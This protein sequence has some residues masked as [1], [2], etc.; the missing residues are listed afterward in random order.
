MSVGFSLPTV[1]SCMWHPREKLMRRWLWHYG[2]DRFTF[3]EALRAQSFPADWLF[4]ESKTKRWKWLAEAFPPKV[5]EH[6][7]SKRLEGSGYVLLDLFAGIGGWSLGAVWS[8]KFRKIIMVEKNREKCVYLQEN[9]SRYSIPYEVVCRDVRSLRGVEADVV[10]AS[11]PCEDMTMLKYLNNN[12]I[13]VGTVPLTVATNRLVDE[14]KPRLALY[15]NVYRKP[16]ADLLKSLGW[17]VERLD[18]SSIIPQRRVRLIGERT[19][20]RQTRFNEP[21]FYRK[22]LEGVADARGA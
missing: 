4:P 9:F 2:R 17:K 5:A 8:G 15:E 19:S 14:V 20:S 11:P 1:T 10:T 13:N 22:L 7:F 18:M 6:I 21:D 16:L 3:E 12:R